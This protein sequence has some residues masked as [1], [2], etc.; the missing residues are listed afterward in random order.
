MVKSTFKAFVN[1]Q[2]NDWET[3]WYA[4]HNSKSSSQMKLPPIESVLFLNG[5]N[6][7]PVF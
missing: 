4:A 3:E 5:E 1:G 2:D 7:P 6:F